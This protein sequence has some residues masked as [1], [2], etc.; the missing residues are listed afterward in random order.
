MFADL[1][2]SSAD[3]GADAE[4]YTCEQTRAALAEYQALPVGSILRTFVEDYGEL[5]DKIR[6][7][8]NL[9]APARCTAEVINR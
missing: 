7:A 3:R 5:R 4:A 9:P 1:Y 2:A 6:A 8:M